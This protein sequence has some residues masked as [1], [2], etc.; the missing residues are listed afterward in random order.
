MARRAFWTGKTATDALIRSTGLVAEAAAPSCSGVFCSTRPEEPALSVIAA[1]HHV[2][3]YRYDRLVE[4]GP[5]VVRLRPA[6]H[7]RTRIPSY[8]LKITPAD[9]FINWQQDPHG[10]WLARLVFPERTR[11]FSV[12]VDL[13]AEMAVINPFDFFVE[14]YA[15]ILPFAYPTIWPRIC[16]YRSWTKM[17]RCSTRPWRRCPAGARQSTSWSSST[18][19]SQRETPLCD[20]HGGRGCRPRTRPCSWAPARAATAPGCWCRSCAGWAWPPASSPA[21]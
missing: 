19:A 1:L 2:T 20:P 4:L 9:H 12:E 11:E 10:N 5:Q 21:T 8:S 7:C 16:A 13:T 3:R 17:A 18:P 14:P 6:P 15:E